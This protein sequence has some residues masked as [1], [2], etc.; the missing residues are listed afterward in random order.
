MAKQ[1]ESNIEVLRIISMFLVLVVHA[2]FLSNEAPTVSLAKHSP[3]TAYTQYFFASISYTCVNTF[4]LITGWFG[5]NIKWRSLCS[6]MFQC[7]FWGLLCY[8]IIL[9]IDT[10]KVLCLNDLYTCLMLHEED[11]WFVKS[12]LF[13]YLLAPLL[14][15]FVEYATP[16][17]FRIVLICF[18][19]FQSIFGWATYAVVFFEAGYSTMSFVGLYLLARYTRLFNPRWSRFLLRT[20][21][22]ILLF[23]IFTTSIISFTTVR[24]GINYVW[25]KMYSYLNPIII[26]ESLLLVV[27][28]SKI[29][30]YNKIV[31][32]IA[33]SAFA[34][35]LLHCNTF[36]F[37]PYYVRC[38]QYIFKNYSGLEYI[39][40]ISLFIV[41]V[42]GCAIIID[43]I[44]I[45]MYRYIYNK[46]EGFFE[47]V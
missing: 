11:Y 41:T 46:V 19:F 22:F 1:R 7:L 16:K 44:R 15:V 28:F 24:Q 29:H 30:F 4:V 8:G 40:Y 3:I 33:L 5:I 47:L 20:D 14:N 26:F 38:S 2:N 35:Y 21:V 42:F 17:Q 37:R 6:L 10:K 9:V 31:N 34:V 43:K 39:I 23:I 18:Y 27:S 25:I 12:Y 32:W 36:L 45:L 13:L